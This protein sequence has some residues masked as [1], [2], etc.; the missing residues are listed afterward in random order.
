MTLNGVDWTQSRRPFL[1][2]G[3]RPRPRAPP[4]RRRRRTRPLPLPPRDRRPH[5]GLRQ[6]ARAA[7]RADGR[8][9]ARPRLRLGLPPRRAP[10]VHVGRQREPRAQGER[11]VRRLPRRQV[12]DATV[13]RGA[14]RRQGAPHPRGRARRLPLHR[15]RRPV[16]V[17]RPG[18]ARRLR[19]RPD[20]RADPR[21]H[22][23][24]GPR[25]RLRAARRRRDARLDLLRQRLVRRVQDGRRRHLLQVL[26]RRRPPPRRRVRRRVPARHRR[27][28]QRRAVGPR[29]RDRRAA[30]R[31]LPGRRA[32]GAERRGGGGA[33]GSDALPDEGIARSR[34]PRRRATCATTGVCAVVDAAVWEGDAGDAGDVRERHGDDVPRAQVRRPAGLQPRDARRARHAQRRLAR[35][36]RALV[37]GGEVHGVR[38]A[39]G[40]DLAPA[41]DGRAGRARRTS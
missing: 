17:L 41:A 15:P 23:R 20:R 14:H 29:R 28:R 39:R 16:H 2:Y 38:P 9:H 27:Q 3:A 25:H 21:R 35:R 22:A 13:R 36:R 7:G 31:R 6:P 18:E 32:V 19:R 8:G 30:R 5:A 10:Q 40:A 24:L 11:D 26:D 33:R 4:P 34:A 12:R 1:Y 37:L